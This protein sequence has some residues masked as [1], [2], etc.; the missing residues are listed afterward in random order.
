MIRA[1]KLVSHNTR[2]WLFSCPI[3]A[4]HRCLFMSIS[5]HFLAQ[6]FRGNDTVGDSVATKSEGKKA[7]RMFPIGTGVSQSVMG[8]AK[9]PGP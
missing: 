5:P 8:L 6:N 9:S 3:K 1:I 4:E 7:Q 2:D